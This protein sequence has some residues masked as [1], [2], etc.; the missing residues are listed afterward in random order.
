MVDIYENTEDYNPNKNKILTKIFIVFDDMIADI[1]EKLNPIVTELFITGR[2]L[3]I[4]Q[5]YFVVT[6]DIRLNSMHYFIMKTPNKQE[7]TQIAFH[8]SPGIYCKHFMNLYKKCTEKNIYF[9][10]YWC[11]S[12]I[13]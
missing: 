4:T 1:L 13:R 2:I 10:C 12:C 3:N 11:Y 6:K 5:H 7:L 8:N 9:F